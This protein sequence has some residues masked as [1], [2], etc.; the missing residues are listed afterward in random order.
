M[1]TARF[2]AAAA[3]SV[4]ERISCASQEVRSLACNEIAQLAG[5]L[6]CP[7]SSCEVLS[8]TTRPHLSTPAALLVRVLALQFLRQQQRHGNR[9]VPLPKG[10]DNCG[11][12]S[13]GAAPRETGTA[14][15]GATQSS[16]TW[17]K[18]KRAAQP[19]EDGDGKRRRGP[20]PLQRLCEQLCSPDNSDN[21]Q[22]HS[23]WMCT[24]AYIAWQL[25]PQLS[26]GDLAA[27]AAAVLRGCNALLVA[28]TVD[29]GADLA[30]A[31][32]LMA[33]EG[34]AAAAWGVPRHHRC[35]A[36]ASIVCVARPST[37]H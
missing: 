27:I 6:D 32:G 9:S 4:H 26:A 35:G 28:E 20:K 3:K 19:G 10:G 17:T 16:V 14:Q 2:F 13:N 12:R 34:V 30:L 31:W 22:G 1:D 7:S 33:L 29:Y 15:N 23:A 11:S 25:A 18:G 24:A 21:S 37:G 8:S 36:R 5:P